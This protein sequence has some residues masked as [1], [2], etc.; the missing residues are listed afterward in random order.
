MP[1]PKHNELRLP[2]LQFLKTYGAA[3][4]KE[5][6]EPLSKSLGLTDEEVEQ[7][8]PSGNGP[9]F[10]DRISWALTYLAL[11]DLVSRPRRAIYEI[12]PKGIEMLST[13]AMIDSYI[14]K[15]MT[16]REAGKAEDSTVEVIETK[17]LTQEKLLSKEK[18]TPQEKLYQSYNNI[19]Q[20]VMDEILDTVISK[21]PRAFE[22]L[23]VALL[24]KMGYGGEVKDS[25]TV[26][27]ATNDKGIDGIIKEDILG[28][29][30][31]YIQAKK[32]SRTNGIGS[33]DVRNFAGSLL[34]TQSRKGIFITTSYYT[35]PALDY[36]KGLNGMPTI[37]LISGEELAG[38]IY[39]YGL[40]MQ[41]EQVITI[42]KL[43]S[44][45]WD[46][47]EDKK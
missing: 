12:T 28:L 9:M 3:G 13:P 43:D 17:P 5:M 16:Q 6:V 23:V 46:A 11:T 8:Y 40:G 22:H 27:Q 14:D 4:S 45:F 18:L 41:S 1:I 31:I 25:G 37:V 33:E 39:E 21:S 10:K 47:M 35:Q 36:V 20:S 42:K 38:H 15:K 34:V 24:Q 26:T 7:M 30:R 44:D 2:V 32:Y 29:G 19:K